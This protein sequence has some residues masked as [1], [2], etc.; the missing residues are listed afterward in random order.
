MAN[1]DKNIVITPNVGSSSDDPKI[2]FT[3]A[4]TAGAYPITL[5]TYPTS[6]GSL[7]FEG[8]AGQ[9][10]SI[11][12]SLTG[13]IYSVN[14]VS[15]IPSIEVLDTGL[16]K[17]AQYSGNVLIG[18]GTDAGYKFQINASGIGSKL[19]KASYSGGIPLYG[20]SDTSGSGITN[21]DPY[22]SGALVYFNGTTTYFY[23]GSS[24]ALTTT[25]SY[26]TGGSSLRA[27]L[28][29]DSDDTSY[30]TNPAGTSSLN[31]IDYVRSNHDVYIDSNYGYG[32]VGAYS[33]YR[34]QGI[35]AMGDSYKLP[36]DGTTTGNLYG[37]AW[38]YPN[39]GGA[40]GYL[41]SHGL[42]L[43]QNGSFMAA[44]STNGT[45]SADVRGTI[46][47][48]Y[49]NS[50]YYTNPEGTSQFAL[51]YAND[52]F[53]PQGGCGIYWSSYDR[54][55][56]AADNDY[57]YGHIGTYGGGLNGWRGYGVYPNNCILMSNG[58][59]FG[60]YNPASGVW[61]MQTSD[62]VGSNMT[63][64]GNVT[65]YSD[66]RLKDNVRD[67]DDVLVRRDG[68][69]LAAIKYERNGRTRIGYG[70][71]TLR[72]NNCAEFVHEADDDM[73]IATG[74]GTLSVDYGETTA[75]LAV[76]SKLTDDKVTILE[77]RIKALEQII[78]KLTGE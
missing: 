73:K 75:V 50:S 54:G 32:L 46:F 14:D 67:I 52:W 31:R 44:L 70:A 76:V 16:V 11:T 37:M 69:A 64:Y 18:T 21:T 78:I 57:S 66:L 47:Y 77:E 10:F 13:T 62:T 4:N 72:D 22:T 45:F 53:R 28:F 6:N 30:Y 12:N 58:S 35:F 27:P 34:Y 25:S 5:R 42:L 48:D 56:R 2:V 3:G 60:F 23:S 63:F 36:A 43:L 1:S 9:L 26:A 40:A 41:N 38:S 68:L 20:Y 7:S 59:T 51:V 74:T 15:G 33:S 24:V 29:Y 8:S 55:I 39:A 19:F 49:N 71:Q 61:V 17:L 65:A